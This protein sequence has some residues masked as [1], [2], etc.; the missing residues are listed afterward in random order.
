MGPGEGS[1]ADTSVG[2][3]LGMVERMPSEEPM[4][5][6]LSAAAVS[7]RLISCSNLRKFRSFPFSMDLLR[8]NKLQD[9]GLW[10]CEKPISIGTLL[11]LA[12]S[13]LLSASSLAR[14]WV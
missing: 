9:C 14:V 11:L 10:V 7:G 4:Q 12:P 3:S 5:S 1:T 2:I 8:L 6:D 13:S